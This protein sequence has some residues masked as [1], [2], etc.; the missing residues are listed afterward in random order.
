MIFRKQKAFLDARGRYE[1]VSGKRQ[2]AEHML[3]DSRAGILAAKL[4]EG[5][6]CPVCG[7]L[8]HPEPARLLESSISEDDFKGLQEEETG[9]TRKR[10]MQI[11]RRR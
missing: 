1:E 8:H 10:T 7:S 5:E 4:V 2:E 11:Q 9:F 3:E 6:K